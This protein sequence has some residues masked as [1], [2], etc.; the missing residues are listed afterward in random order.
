MIGDYLGY[1]KR[2]Q[3]YWD[4]LQ[5]FKKKLPEFVYIAIYGFNRRVARPAYYEKLLRDF[6][7]ENILL[8]IKKMKLPQQVDRLATPGVI[9]GLVK[10]GW[11][12]ETARKSLIEILKKFDATQLV[13][14]LTTQGVVERLADNG[15]AK[16]V[17]QL[18]GKLNPDQQTVVLTTRDVVWALAHYREEVSLVALIEKLASHQQEAILDTPKV[19]LCLYWCRQG[20][21]VQ[22]IRA[23]F[24]NVGRPAHT[25]SPTSSKT[26]PFCS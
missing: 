4:L 10:H 13:D 2:D 11:P 9:V 20:E 3:K 18:I 6:R 22:K 7:V 19:N 24:N 23:K 25:F 5:K 12:G 26:E 14:V 21:A 16:H 1:R 17:V 15:Y 8:D